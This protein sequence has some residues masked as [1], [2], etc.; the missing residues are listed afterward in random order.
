MGNCTITALPARHFSGRS[1]LNRFHTLW[2]S[3]AIKGP[4]HN[5]YFGADSGYYDGFK[6]IGDR[7]GPFDLT[8][9]DTG[10][11]NPEWEQIHMGPENAIRANQDLRGKLL[12]P[13]HWGTFPLAFHPWTEPVERVMVAAEAAGVQLLL[14]APGET[15]DVDA[16]S[17]VNKWWL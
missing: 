10:A 4:D 5:V 1:L 12:M 13:I 17:Y 16:G 3:Y 2:G 6:K 7:L 11:Y 14:P 8:M 15:R 9:L